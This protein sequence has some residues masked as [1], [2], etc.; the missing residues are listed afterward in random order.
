M[1]RGYCESLFPISNVILLCTL[2]NAHRA[3]LRIVA[4][5]LPVNAGEY[6]VPT[7]WMHTKPFFRSAGKLASALSAATPAPIANPRRQSVSILPRDLNR[8]TSKTRISD[9]SNGS[10]WATPQAAGCPIR[11]EV[12]PESWCNVWPRDVH[13][14]FFPITRGS[15]NVPSD[16]RSWSSECR[17]LR[18]ASGSRRFS[19]AVCDRSPGTGSSVQSMCREKVPW[20]GSECLELE[21]AATPVWSFDNRW[22]RVKGSVHLQHIFL[23][24]S[25]HDSH[26]FAYAQ[27]RASAEF[28]VVELPKLRQR[29]YTELGIRAHLSVQ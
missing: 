8:K 24:G 18:R 29:I 16:Y 17:G 14:P 15:P 7:M 6:I 27:G 3:V 23:L 19:P 2:Q 11:Q 10:L 12:G 13:A 5:T 4:R 21:A 1:D 25:P 26:G 28:A 9:D 22:Y 20:S